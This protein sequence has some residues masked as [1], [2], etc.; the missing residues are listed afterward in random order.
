MAATKDDP[1][2]YSKGLGTTE[3]GANAAPVDTR[4]AGSGAN[5]HVAEAFANAGVTTFE[6]IFTALGEQGKEVLSNVGEFAKEAAPGLFS[7]NRNNRELF[8]SGLRFMG[9]NN[10]LTGQSGWGEGLNSLDR[11]M[12]TN[13]AEEEAQLGRENLLELEGMQVDGREA[14]ARIR[15]DAITEAARTRDEG[16]SIRARDKRKNER[17]DTLAENTR[18]DTA[19]EIIAE[20][21]VV[22]AAVKAEKGGY[23]ESQVMELLDM[24]EGW[25]KSMTN[26]AY[27][28]GGTTLAAITKAVAGGKDAPAASPA[29][30]VQTA[31]GRLQP[32][33]KRLR[34]G[35]GRSKF[36]T[37]DNLAAPLFQLRP[38]EQ[39]L[40]NVLARG[41]LE[42]GFKE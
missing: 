7:P 40:L 23:T 39:E 21:K 28:A 5:A 16:E 13:R 9:P 11:M 41:G 37:D 32:L 4:T 18:E 31:L 33:I 8:F 34:P 15:A 35:S 25:Q 6:E 2:G 22:A 24:M 30:R 10:Y 26:A 17:V 19:K 14:A 1:N 12:D 36:R 42:P 3:I 29:Q 27:A 20:A 38:H